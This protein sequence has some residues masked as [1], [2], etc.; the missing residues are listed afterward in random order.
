MRRD[1]SSWNQ[2]QFSPVSQAEYAKV[3]PVQGE[4][5]LDPF[6]VC[7]VR[8]RCV[9]KL[10]SQAF[11]LGKDRGNTGQVRLSQRNEFKRAAIERGQKFSDCLGVCAQEPCRLGDHQPT[12]GSEPRM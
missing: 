9:G 12:V 6:T 8:Q 1:R 7:Q 10:Y 5:R 4:D 2:A 11:I 3:A